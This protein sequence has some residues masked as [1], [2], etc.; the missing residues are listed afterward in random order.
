MH[1]DTQVI[2]IIFSERQILA[3]EKIH[4]VS[5]PSIWPMFAPEMTSRVKVIMFMA[6]KVFRMNHKS[7]RWIIAGVT[8]IF[9]VRKSRVQLLFLNLYFLVLLP[10]CAPFEVALI[11]ISCISCCGFKVCIYFLLLKRN[12]TNACEERVLYLSPKIFFCKLWTSC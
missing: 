8:K 4:L 5:T 11:G 12:K 7:L 3:L 9:I 1:K 6:W 2:Y 10:L